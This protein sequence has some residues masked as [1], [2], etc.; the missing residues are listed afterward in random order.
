MKSDFNKSEIN[1]PQGH[2]V[3][4]AHINNKW[5]VAK[6][7]LPFILISSLVT[8]I[9]IWTG[10]IYLA[11]CTGILSLFIIYF[12]RDPERYHDATG[13]AVL[14]PAD[15]KIIEIRTLNNNQ[16]PIN[17]PAVKISI[18][19]TIFNVHVNRSPIRGIIRNITYN[20]GKFFS[21]N[22]DKASQL[23]ENNLMLLEAMDGR[24]I[25]VIQIAGLIARRIV[26]WVKKEEGVKAGQRFGLIRFG[27]RLEVFL[28]KDS[29]IIV[30]VGQ[31]VKAGT[32][33]IGY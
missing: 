26:C 10:P 13:N 6:E 11:I 28:P 29:K 21:A 30:K 20:P 32:T 2:P 1:V 25:A 23:N 24:K 9:L 18:F 3:D 33:I 19:M 17:Q 22:L 12:F 31:K 8:C 5:P 14:T 15:G 16:N 7:G 4:H 27:S